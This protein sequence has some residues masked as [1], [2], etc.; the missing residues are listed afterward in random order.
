MLIDVAD[1][2]ALPVEDGGVDLVL[3]S[4][5][6]NAN[7][8]YAG[9]NDCLPWK[10]YLGLVGEW[11]AEMKR[12]IAPGGFVVLNL[13]F[14]I[15]LRPADADLKASRNRRDVLPLSLEWIY[16]MQR[17]GFLFRGEHIWLKYPSVEDV[18]RHSPRY[19]T[20]RCPA[21]INT[22]EGMFVFMDGEPAR[23]GRG[24][25]KRDYERNK[26]R[27]DDA[28]SLW[29]IPNSKDMTPRRWHP[30]P[31]PEELAA[32]AIRLYSWE[33]DVVLDPFCGSGVVP[34]VAESL[35]RDGMGFDISRVTVEKARET[36]ADVVKKKKGKKPR[37][38]RL[39]AGVKG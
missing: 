31:W 19:G 6:Y 21:I 22:A 10:E 12:V 34:K 37:Q 17:E 25:K 13:A 11:C 14:D 28:S 24:D 15:R 30:C 38:Q 1:A 5:P 7:L 26:L 36:V 16:R 9:W 39:F 2:R 20:H 18:H 32:R 23:R 33:G 8:K 29:C 35:G 4:P 27:V 3:T